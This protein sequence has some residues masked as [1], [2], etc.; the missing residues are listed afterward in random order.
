MIV[1]DRPTEKAARPEGVVTLKRICAIKGHSCM[2]GGRG[3]CWGLPRAGWGAQV[4]HSRSLLG[5]LQRSSQLQLP[6][7][8][9]KA[10]QPP[11]RLPQW[12]IMDLQN[13]CAVSSAEM[14]CQLHAVPAPRSRS[15][16]VM[17]AVTT[18]QAWGDGS[19]HHAPSCSCKDA[20]RHTRL[21]PAKGSS[22]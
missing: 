18:A 21:L 10:R 22:T 17:T 2:A 13:I 6:M 3:E 12:L 19:A 4:G 14:P 7:Q 1:P 16:G 5:P 8:L 9:P 11:G 20:V 15:Q